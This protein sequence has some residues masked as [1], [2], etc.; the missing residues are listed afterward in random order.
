MP[1]YA[2]GSPVR[3]ST[4]I[5]DITGTLTTPGAILLRVKRPDGTFLPDYT[6]PAADSTGKYH[7][8]VPSS[9]LVQLG[10]F[11][12]AWI[13]T[14]TAAGVSPAASFELVDPFAPLHITL[15]D[16]KARL[17]LDKVT[18]VDQGRDDELQAFIASAVAEQE[19]RVGPVAPRTVTETVYGHFGR[20]ALS[21]R[22]VLS[23]TSA[24]LNGSSVD[25]S[26]WRV[27]SPMSGLI[28]AGTGAYWGG[29]Y[30]TAGG[31]YT[32][33]Y[34]AGRNPVPADLTEAALLRVQASYE[35]QRGPAGLPLADQ[36][37]AGFG[38]SYP[39]LAQA[40]SKEAPYVLPVIA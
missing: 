13:T 30:G 14:G 8:D 2:V 17:Q 39:L 5:R 32:I 33:T 21:T 36:Q 10:H 6:S 9:D 19:A 26:T 37:D 35:T 16:A 4:E 7:Q 27:P 34:T 12:Y 24:T 28:E 20:L 31:L 11:Q 22:P 29:S 40:E 1:R 23:V 3:V 38:S 18:T 25:V 15:A